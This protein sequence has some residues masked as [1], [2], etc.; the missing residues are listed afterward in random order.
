MSNVYLRDCV[1]KRNKYYI[2]RWGD[3]LISETEG[4]LLRYNKFS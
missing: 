2:I 4:M 3:Y 1:Q